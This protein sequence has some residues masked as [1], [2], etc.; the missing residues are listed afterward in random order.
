MNKIQIIN[1]FQRQ[2][3]KKIIIMPD[4]LHFRISL[5]SDI[6][7]FGKVLI[8]LLLCIYLIIGLPIILFY[9][10]L[11]PFYFGMAKDDALISIFNQHR[12]S[13]ERLR[14][15]GDS[16]P[17]WSYGMLGLSVDGQLSDSQKKEYTKLI[18]EIGH[19]VRVSKESVFVDEPDASQ[20]VRA[21]QELKF[22]FGM[23][24]GFFDGA[25]WS[26]R[27]QYISLEKWKDIAFVDNL[28]NPASLKQLGLFARQIDGNWFITLEQSNYKLQF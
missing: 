10:L 27:I 23:G 11:N 13:F 1:C 17:D 14:L 2:K 20:G 6:I 18:S 22:I 21:N 4:R 9:I 16:G 24:G 25:R 26:K 28:N 19:G 12:E 5:F 8:N 7:F 15:L 3:S